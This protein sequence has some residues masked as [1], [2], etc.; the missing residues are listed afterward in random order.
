LAEQCDILIMNAYIR[1]Y[2]HD[3]RFNIA[4]SEGKIV[5]IGDSRPCRASIEIDAE[6]NLVTESLAN[7]HIHLCKVYT[8]DLVGD[9]VLMRDQSGMM[10]DSLLAIEIASRV[11]DIYKEDW[12]YRNA[13]RAIA[14]IIKY[15]VL[16]VRHSS[17]RIA[18][19][20]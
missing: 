1:S 9:E 14:E 8:I 2:P 18:R 20:D 19:L 4:V 13:R 17:I 11:K 7:P 10:E 3:R 16:H 5:Y 12:I 6:G 15:G